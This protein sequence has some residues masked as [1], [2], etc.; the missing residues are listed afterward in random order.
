[1]F[2]ELINPSLDVWAIKAVTLLTVVCSISVVSW[3]LLCM[4]L[5]VREI[6]STYEP[7]EESAGPAERQIIVPGMLQWNCLR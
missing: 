1:M 2:F 5:K 7:N 6:T 4:L 3:L